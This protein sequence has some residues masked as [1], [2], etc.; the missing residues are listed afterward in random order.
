[1]VTGLQNTIEKTVQRKKSNTSI[2]SNKSLKLSIQFSLDG[3]SF[4]VINKDTNKDVFFTSYSFEE[5]LKSPTELLEN[6][7][8]IF[9]TDKNLQH[10]FDEVAVIHQNNLNTLVPQD[11]FD[12]KH[13]LTYLDYN[14]KTLPTDLA[15]FDE[16]DDL[17]ANN[18]FIPYT[19]VNN[20]LFQHFGAFEYKH[21][22]TV[23]IEKLLTLESSNDTNMYVN[24]SESTFEIAV[25]RDKNLLLLNVFSYK[26][27]E[28]FLYYILFVA[29]QLKLDT[30]SFNLY[31]SGDIS[32]N[33][34][35]YKLAYNYIKNISLLESKNELFNHLNIPKHSNFMLLFS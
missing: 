21:H 5:T 24:V 29:E 7:T 6:I 18:V 8:Y 35:M 27:K 17:K 26:T 4:C 30:E 32:E 3:F 33:S 34:E 28:D 19:N 13:L 10:D 1:M 31:F 20:Y 16:I 23:F 2:E 14:I 9:K 15:A 25:L 22:T 11:Y 12:E